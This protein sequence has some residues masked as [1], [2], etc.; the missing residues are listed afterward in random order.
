MRN[1]LTSACCLL[2]RFY[3][4]CVSP[5]LPPCC[6]FYPSCSHYALEA[7]RKYGPFR[8]FSLTARRIARCNPYCEGGF[9]PVP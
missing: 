2:I 7:F 4:V 5:F 8:G 9:D 6:R 1:F 3:Q